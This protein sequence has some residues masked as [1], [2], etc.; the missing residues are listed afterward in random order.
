[1]TVEINLTEQEIA[2]LKEATCQTDVAA[3]VRTAMIEYLNC[4]RRQR[5]K[6]LSGQVEMEENWLQ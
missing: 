6:E 5:L 2:E 1:M 3:A 4:V